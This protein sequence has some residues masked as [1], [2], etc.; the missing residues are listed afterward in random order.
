MIRTDP[1]EPGRGFTLIELLVVISIISI[2]I[3]LLLPGLGAA[4]EA[5]RGVGCQAMLRSMAQGQM[6]Y[7]N[8]FQDF[9]AGPTT[10]GYSG[11]VAQSGNQRY[12]HDT[13]PAMPTSTHDW[14][15]PTLGDSLNLPANRAERTAAIFETL[16]CP[17]ARQFNQRVFDQASMGDREEFERLLATERIRQIS[18]LAPAGFHYWSG[19]KTQAQKDELNGQCGGQATISIPSPVR[20]P[21]AYRPRLDQIGAQPSRKV[22]VADGTRY[23]ASTNT[24][25]L[26]D[27][28]ID[29]TPRW[30]GCFTDA[31][32]I[33]HGSAA[34]G[35][36]PNAQASPGRHRLSFRH[37]IGALNAAFFDGHV[38]RMRAS[39]AWED[40]EP[41]YP[42]GSLFEPDGDATPESVEF[43]DSRSKQIP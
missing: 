24:G 6:M 23:L 10:S 5:A 16:R 43:Y 37:P 22:I 31:G 8:T 26:L 34:W 27:F 19:A 1:S 9:F 39:R 3:S 4:R 38:G 7:M 25:P 33:F 30:Y 32:P 40:A 28:D 15:S 11:Q 12:I 29:A 21:A 14:I 17:S 18:Y 13:H 35:R 20:V 36:G 2:L 41:W 42:G